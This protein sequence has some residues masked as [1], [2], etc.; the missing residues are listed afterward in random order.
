[1]VAAKLRVD[2]SAQNRKAT[3]VR[4]PSRSGNCCTCGCTCVR[5]RTCRSHGVLP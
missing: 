5:T 1:M 4:L 3:L 2:L